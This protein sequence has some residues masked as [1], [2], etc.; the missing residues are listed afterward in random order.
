MD[1]KKSVLPLEC[2]ELSGVVHEIVVEMVLVGGN[3]EEVVAV[4]MVAPEK[5][6]V[7]MIVVEMVALEMTVLGIVL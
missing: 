1:R 3:V 5:V 4:E 2:G 7:E 6:V